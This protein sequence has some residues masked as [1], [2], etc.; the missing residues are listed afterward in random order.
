[1]LSVQ[2]PAVHAEEPPAEQD[3][4]AEIIAE[5]TMQEEIT[6]EEE[7]AAEELAE[8]EETVTEEEI[9]ETEET[10]PAEAEEPAETV[11]PY[12]TEE[13]AETDVPEEPEE[14]VI[15]EETPEAEEITEPAETEEPTEE[16]Q[17]E[18][19]AVPEE[20][21]ETDEIEAEETEEELIAEETL[22]GIEL[23]SEPISGRA[24]IEETAIQI[25]SAA[26]GAGR[27]ITVKGFYAEG[28]DDAYLIAE[29]KTTRYY[30]HSGH[31]YPS[32]FSFDNV[33]V[34]L[35]E[36]V[37]TLR[38]AKAEV[39]DGKTILK[40][41]PAYDVKLRVLPTPQVT[42]TQ[43]D[44]GLG[45]GVMQVKL[46]DLTYVYD[47]YVTKRD[48][49]DA[50]PFLWT[51]TE[52]SELN[53]KAVKGVYSYKE[54]DQIIYAAWY[55]FKYRGVSIPGE[56]VIDSD[57]ATV[58]VTSTIAP[59]TVDAKIQKNGTDYGSTANPYVMTYKG[60]TAQ[61]TSDLYG[62]GHVDDKRLTYKSDNTKVVTVDTTGTVK[63]VGNGSA[64]I[65]VRS[66][67][68]PDYLG[69]VHIN[70]ELVSPKTFK[71]D[72]EASP[73]VP[74]HGLKLI[75]EDGQGAVEFSLKV[76]TDSIPG[77]A[78]VP[79]TFTVTGGNMK[80]YQGAAMGDGSWPSDASNPDK[81]N[82]ETCFKTTY[83]RDITTFIVP[84]GAQI[85]LLAVGGGHYTVTAEAMGKTATVT[86]DIDGF[87][88]VEGSDCQPAYGAQ[89]YRAGKLVTGW[90]TY[91][92]YNEVF[93]YGDKAL[94]GTP[95]EM[96]DRWV[97]YVD[98]ATKIVTE[99]GI[100]KIGN[101]LYLFDSDCY[102]QFEY[103]D[104]YDN[105]IQSV[106]HAFNYGTGDWDWV[107]VDTD[108]SLM[109]G[110]QTVSTS[111][112][113][114][115][116]GDH[117][118]DPAT[119]FMAVR[120]WVPT[121][122]G[123]GVTW[124]DGDGLNRDDNCISL[125]NVTGAHELG[126]YWYIF[127]NGA[128]QTGWAYFAYDEEAG[129][130]VVTTAKNG[131]MKM[132]CDPG[133]EGRVMEYYFTVSG[134]KYYG[135]TIGSGY[136]SGAVILPEKY[137]GEMLDVK[138]VKYIPWGNGIAGPDGSLIE[139][140]MIRTYLPLHGYET[141][142][143]NADGIRVEDEWVTIKGKSY[144]FDS[145][146]Y[147][148][149]TEIPMDMYVYEGA[150]ERQVTAKF[151]N[152]KTG[153][154]YYCGD[155]SGGILKNIV[156]YEFN[157]S[158]MV[159]YIVLDKNGYKV[160]NTVVKARAVLGDSTLYTYTVNSKGEILRT[161]GSDHMIV[162]VNK[163]AYVIG[164][165]GKVYTEPGLVALGYPSDP[166]EYADAA[167]LDK[168]GQVVRNSFVTINIGGK[169]YQ[170][171]CDEDG[172]CGATNDSMSSKEIVQV[173]KGKTY[174]LKLIENAFMGMGLYVLDKPAKADWI[175][176][177]GGHAYYINKDGTVKTGF[178]SEN[179]MKTYFA[180]RNGNVRPLDAHNNGNLDYPTIYRI[181]K[182]NY[183]F[184]DEGV[185]LTG[186]IH[187]D[188]A[189]IWDLASEQPLV[190]YTDEV[191]YFDPKTG[192]AVSGW[193]TLPK[194]LVINGELSMGSEDTG[195]D[196][197]AW[198]YYGNDTSVVNTSSSK[199]KLYFNADGVLTRNTELKIGKT[200]Y[201]FGADGSANAK[202]GWTDAN[203][204]YYI[205]KNGQLAVGRKKID[206]QYYYF[207]STGRKQMN[208]LI[209]TGKKWYF[210]DEDGVQATPV[211]TTSP[212]YNMNLYGSTKVALKAVWAKDGSLSKIVY[213]NSG[214]PAAGV[215]V[216][217]GTYD[218]NY[219]IYNS[220][221]LDSKGLP[222]TGPVYD[223]QQGSEKYAFLY[224]TDGS[225]VKAGSSGFNSLVKYGKKF[226]L[227]DDDLLLSG[228]TA[229][230]EVLDG[231][232]VGLSA[233][234]QKT[235]EFYQTIAKNLSTDL[236]VIVN[237]DGSVCANQVVPAEID[238][239]I[240]Y[241]HTNS[242]GI[243]LEFYTPIYKFN[244]KWYASGPVNF[245][246]Q[247]ERGNYYKAQ[248]KTKSTGE[249]IGVYDAET[250]KALTGTFESML[251]Y[252]SL[253]KGKPQTGNIK[254]EGATYWLDGQAG[255]YI[256][257]P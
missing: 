228:Y 206:G 10:E 219:D 184:N 230:A 16:I 250:G 68:D 237:T 94:K 175:V 136:P 125:E 144:Y 197:E 8:P 150:I 224:N 225:K 55:D 20:P 61:I 128:R 200:T 204:L 71:F 121:R 236:Y 192:A 242:M 118:F 33:E 156:L 84:Q 2:M 110:W 64:V 101:K 154:T 221:M 86:I 75:I 46:P 233:A 32:D 186:W 146:G 168:K 115:A 90:V 209:R 85:H 241:W 199:G 195:V 208:K 140:T 138:K 247:D 249:L 51:L 67:A 229:S 44:D 74:D 176:D 76:V 181:G 122:S 117:Y 11:I 25:T 89:F 239:T 190:T 57:T 58:S 17:P 36:G 77:G 106:S 14:T 37:Y 214:K 124:V 19:T 40:V 63:A 137:L 9:T 131:I 45:T 213:N 133:Y 60:E 167:Y 49:P 201:L 13:P 217:F 43:Q 235:M 97:Y 38:A 218:P 103:D 3:E 123:K 178:I 41:S 82:D 98:P 96:A 65:T 191:F 244:K 59:Y 232:L 177:D 193:K 158:E 83:T 53:A 163:K 105:T 6:A 159:P 62:N 93:I 4:P 160:S 194:P 220:F 99:G 29:N 179:G 116:G 238:G 170:I 252:I 112:Y 223:V 119:G 70:V 111:T 1:M 142:Y 187:F 172:E 143:A 18:E 180:Y 47:L 139:S 174:I 92:H 202:T 95:A 165:D 50:V 215:V 80:I 157:G 212:D 52:S 39:V 147:L 162:Y 152:E 66:A 256:Y 88:A 113:P 211:L 257:H 198:Y 134:K 166:M 141:M 7:P 149:K 135:E 31:Y 185:M 22:E 132:Y 72:L 145:N 21:A 151:V 109:S 15:P 12:E 253:K 205:V 104:T 126:G 196:N 28:A 87:T 35:P 73:A 189:G 161:L 245:N 127:K 234:E 255:T 169:N 188:K 171:Y 231:N 102:L 69:Y 108:G 24:A 78:S 183:F 56:I 153:Y 26:K 34:N 240:Q 182:K 129:S 210:Y 216:N 207:D 155:G 100:R 42:V 81:F 30:L 248:I 251:Y 243:P 246:L 203:K 222:S 54:P 173:I 27:Q 130:F 23:M 91:D 79:V 164:S 48:T 120:S 227:M 254:Y 114:V 107:F 148:S 5:E 226:Y